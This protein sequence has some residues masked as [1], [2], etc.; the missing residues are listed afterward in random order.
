MDVNIQI[1][2]ICELLTLIGAV[3]YLVS[4]IIEVH[5][6]GYVLYFESLVL[7]IPQVSPFRIKKL[8]FGSILVWL[9]SKN[10]VP[11]FFTVDSFNASSSFGLL[12]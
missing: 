9:S 4:N 1:R 6:T 7:Y 11:R 2:L 5:Y 3:M 8:F 10:F 12:V